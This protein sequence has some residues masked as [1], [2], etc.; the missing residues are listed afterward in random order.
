MELTFYGKVD[1]NGTIIL[2]KRIRKEVSKMLAGKS[3]EVIFRRKK[4]HRTTSQNAYY[5]AVVVP[6]ILEEFVNLGNNLQV[7]NKEH[8]ELVHGMLKDMFLPAKEVTDADGVAIKLPPTT[9]DLSTFE[10]MEYLEK[11]CQF[12]AERL[13]LVIPAPEMQGEFWG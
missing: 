12:A 11:V 2:P 6:L 9:K 13:Q 5:W 10:F 4:K 8:I 3:I 1:Q 7:G